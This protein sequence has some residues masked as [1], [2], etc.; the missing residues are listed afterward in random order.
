MVLK[1]QFKFALLISVFGTS[2]NVA[3]SHSVMSST[4]LFNILNGHPRFIERQ[5]NLSTEII[6][7]DRK[8]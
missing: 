6:N 5:V 4:Y 8:H 1:I 3:A 2:Q 7:K